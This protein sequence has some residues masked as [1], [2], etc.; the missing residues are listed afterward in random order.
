MVGRSIAGGSIF[1]RMFI[2]ISIRGWGG[3]KY[4]VQ[5]SGYSIL[6]N[7]PFARALQDEQERYRGTGGASE[8]NSH[9]GFVPAFYDLVDERLYLS[10]Y[11]DGSQA[12]VHVLEGLPE[13]LRRRDHYQR[14]LVVG[15]LRGNRFYTREQA[16]GL[17]EKL[18]L[19]ATA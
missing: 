19:Q 3:M 7:E 14:D 16:A 4:Y 18:R 13:K 8:H 12:S 5:G 10:T 11:R 17:I 2:R 15:F 6:C 1:L 9:F